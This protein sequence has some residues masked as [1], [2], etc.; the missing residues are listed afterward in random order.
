MSRLYEAC[1]YNNVEV[2]SDQNFIQNVQA[3]SGSERCAIGNHPIP[4]HMK[5]GSQQVSF[6]LLL[7]SLGADLDVTKFILHKISSDITKRD[8]RNETALHKACKSKVQD[9]EKAEFLVSKYPDL[10]YFGTS[11]GTLPLHVAAKHNKVRCLEILL[12]HEPE[13]VNK[14]TS[15]GMTP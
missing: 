2:L 6:F 10:M 14:I 12:K 9:V 15:R 1:R 11:C 3:L 13:S 4:V 8:S 5:D 7:A